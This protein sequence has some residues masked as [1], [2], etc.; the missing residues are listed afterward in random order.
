M[1]EN[2]PKSASPL[3]HPTWPRAR[4]DN[5]P[6]PERAENCCVI[7]FSGALFTGIEFLMRNYIYGYSQNIVRCI[8]CA[9]NEFVG[10]N[11]SLKIGS[12]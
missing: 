4:F 3:P 1:P 11:V 5:G 2:G 6:H 8:L 10:L 12:G 7:A 9:L